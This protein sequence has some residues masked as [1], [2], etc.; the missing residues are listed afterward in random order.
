MG[1]SCILQRL[2]QDVFKTEHEITIGVEFGAFVMRIEGKIIKLMIWDTAG[3]EQF[4]SI[5]KLFYKNSDAA[6]IVYD[7]TR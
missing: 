7:V 6:V 2:T 3:Q 4:R 5:T 1:K